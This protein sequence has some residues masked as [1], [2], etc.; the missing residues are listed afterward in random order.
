MLPR[1]TS[2]LA[3]A[4]FILFVT[5]FGACVAGVCLAEPD[6][7]FL[8]ALGRFIFEKATIPDTDPF[9]F[10]CAGSHLVVYQWLTEVI[11]FG[12]FKI[13]GAVGLTVLTAT[14]LALSF[15]VF[16]SR[17]FGR[18]GVL[19]LKA[20]PLVALVML[21]ALRHASTRPEIFSYA[22]FGAVLETA[23][24]LNWQNRKSTQASDNS[25]PAWRIVIALALLTALWSNL[26]TGFTSGI[27]LI[28]LCLLCSS[29]DRFLCKRDN[30][31]EQST[32]L[33]ALPASLLAS[34][35]NPY[36]SG[37]WMYLPNLFFAPINST[38]NELKP[39]S[40]AEF[41]T[42]LVIPYT[43]LLVLTG[44]AGVVCL[45]QR[46]TMSAMPFGFLLVALYLP[47]RAARL[48]TFS[49][50]LAAAGAAW[51]FASIKPVK[52]EGFAAACRQRL[53][54]LYRPLSGAWSLSTIGF[55]AAGAYLMSFIVPPELPMKT[56][57]FHAPRKAVQY[58][59]QHWTRGHVLNDPHFGDLVMWNCNP[60]PK[61]YI[62]SRYD[63]Y[64]QQVQDDYWRM[65]RATA[66]ARALLI[67]Y[68]IEWIFLP[69]Q[70]E[71][72]KTLA[73]SSDWQTCYKDDE[74]AILRRLPK[75]AGNN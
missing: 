75:E 13:G 32:W 42:P 5:V 15:V 18:L 66:D 8:L 30:A 43:L 51:F 16:P 71:L 63:I 14:M 25:A 36:G 48:I 73:A 19:P 22:F 72:V 60:S 65:T 70:A 33:A 11:F 6:T 7:C 10:T 50:L 23:A 12:T 41:G 67:K 2:A 20:L 28:F 35:L 74:A 29:I 45:K 69:P 56:A 54:A 55:A 38:I 27:I 53:D 1:L 37:L 61:L 26:H 39:M 64:P 68:D 21:S 57:A 24:F 58:L 34:L 3:L 49:A 59:C 4:A 9:S 31:K 62:D 17:V 40:P 46:R 47:F 44:I 52:E